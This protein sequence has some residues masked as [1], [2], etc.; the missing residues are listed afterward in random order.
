MQKEWSIFVIWFSRYDFLNNLFSGLFLKYLHSIILHKEGTRRIHKEHSLSGI[1]AKVRER[2]VCQ[3]FTAVLL[4]CALRVPQHWDCA[5][6]YF[7]HWALQV[8]FPTVCEI[9]QRGS[10]RRTDNVHDSIKV[11]YFAPG[12]IFEILLATVDGGHFISPFLAHWKII[13]CWSS[14]LSFQSL[15]RSFWWE[16]HSSKNEVF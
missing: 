13:Q 3:G 1:G 11:V 8:I 4:L 12:L 10:I 6:S 9:I 14:S 7:F 2:I 15:I 16:K 5:L